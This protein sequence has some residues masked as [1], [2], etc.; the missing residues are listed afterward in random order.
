MASGGKKKWTL[1]DLRASLPSYGSRVAIIVIGIVL[2]AGSIIYTS[3]LARQLRIKENQEIELWAYAFSQYGQI[4]GESPMLKNIREMRT[5]IPFVITDFNNQ[6]KMSNLPEEIV[7]DQKLLN[8]E[9]AKLARQNE[10]KVIT[11]WG[12][13]YYMYYGSSKLQRTLAIFPFVQVTIILIFV[14][15]GFITFRTSEEDEQN[16]VWI[17]LAKETAHQLGTPISS[18]LGWL[19][20]L[21]SQDIDP[22]VVEEMDKDLTRL[23]KVADRF[24]KIGSATSLEPV[25]INETVGE[26]VMYFRTRMPKNVALNYNG[27]AIAPVMAMANTA[28]FEWVVENILK[29]SLDA[30]QGQGKIDVVIDSTET[31]VNIDFRDTGKGIAK[32][33]FKRIFEP[34]FTTKTRGWGLGLSLSK[35][36]IEEYHKGKIYVVDSEIGKGTTIRISLQRAYE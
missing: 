2:G 27:F 35:R 4:E 16:K 32:T 1:S 12:W 7:G 34:G 9:V 23:M 14:I 24:S 15:F 31:K 6:Y 5:D 3:N 26:S 11:I 18:L 29:N 8:K 22:S 33:N 10:R 20:Y 21:R 13:N 17:G 36:I 30:L 28:L 19:E 25:I